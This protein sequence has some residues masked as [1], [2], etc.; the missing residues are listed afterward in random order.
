MRQS[1]DVNAFKSHLKHQLLNWWDESGLESLQQHSLPDVQ[2]L[3]WDSLPKSV[4]PQA[5]QLQESHN[6]NGR[7]HLSIIICY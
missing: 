2:Q 3:D 1:C 5:G 4:H 7:F 6:R